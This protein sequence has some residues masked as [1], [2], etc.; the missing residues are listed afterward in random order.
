MN[1]V[2][3][4]YVFSGLTAALYSLHLVAPDTNVETTGRKLMDAIM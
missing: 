4:Q 1:H 3:A 2:S